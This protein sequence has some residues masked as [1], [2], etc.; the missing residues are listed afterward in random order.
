MRPSLIPSLLE[1]LKRN[2]S[3]KNEDLKIFEVSPSF[4]LTDAIPHEV[5]KVSG[6]LYGR[7][8]E[9]SWNQADAEID[10]YDLKG[11]IEKL[12]SSLGITT[13]NIE[14]KS[15]EINY[16]DSNQSASITLSDMDAGFFW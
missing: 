16:L 13:G 11:T 3:R 10:F 5:W 4:T 14:I 8:T 9:K 12:L 6:L 7:R 1:N 2:L 15:S